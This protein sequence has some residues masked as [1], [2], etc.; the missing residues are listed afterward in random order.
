MTVTGNF[1]GYFYQLILTDR[2][3]FMHVF[4]VTD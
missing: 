2:R 3:H 4:H 1:W